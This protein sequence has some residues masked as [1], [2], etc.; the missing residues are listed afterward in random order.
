VS[1]EPLS[2]PSAFTGSPC[3]CVCLPIAV[4][5]S[6]FLNDCYIPPYILFGFSI[7][8][9]PRLPLA[10]TALGAEFVA[11]LLFG[12]ASKENV[13]ELVFIGSQVRGSSSWE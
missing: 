6:L 12:P 9:D 4:R 2:F 13:I 8:F 1:I 3:L 5:F 7:S 10:A 11:E